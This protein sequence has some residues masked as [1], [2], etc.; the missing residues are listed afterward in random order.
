[1]KVSLDESETPR[2]SATSGI[3]P[4]TSSS[5]VYLVAIMRIC[6]WVFGG[7]VAGALAAIIAL[8]TTIH[9]WRI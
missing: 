2:H 9:F 4:T 1:M 5:R 7:L 3:G 8:E 6:L